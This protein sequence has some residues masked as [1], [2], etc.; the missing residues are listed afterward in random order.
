MN[1]TFSSG[2]SA[3]RIGD[4]GD[5]EIVY[6]PNV[7]VPFLAPRYCETISAKPPIDRYGVFWCLNMA[8]WVRYPL[9]LF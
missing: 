4:R 2:Y 8:N 3:G 7:F 9:P 5:R 1:I 6:V